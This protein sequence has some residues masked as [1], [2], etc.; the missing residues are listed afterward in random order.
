MEE[1]HMGHQHI[2]IEDI[3]AVIRA[4]LAVHDASGVKIGSVRDY[5][6]AAGYLVVQTGLISHK[7]LYVPYGAIKSIDPKEVYLSLYEDTL[8][9][10][11]SA[12][13]PATVIVEGDTATTVV[14]S[15]FDGSPAE[16]N[17]VNL[18]MVRR[19]LARDMAVYATSGEK[20][21]NVEGIDLT[22]GY[23]LV[24]QHHFSKEA[25]F[26]PFAAIRTI[27]R[28]FGEVFLAISRDV[29]LKDYAQLND[30]TV[31]RIDTG[32]TR[33]DATGATSEEQPGERS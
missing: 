10:D 33:V 19:D 27:D 17:R 16:F 7:D 2:V 20:I 11:Y 32:T 18:E 28:R 21:G 24:K 31:L 3:D 30:G 22:T 15:G 26:I 1:Q 8:T 9:G 12:P 13:P 29:L 5:S 23:M 6:T 14:S 4:G 25:F